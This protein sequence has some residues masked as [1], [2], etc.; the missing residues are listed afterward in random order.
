MQ[1]KI[2][3]TNYETY[4]LL[5][6]DDELSGN[7]RTEVETFLQQHPETQPL[8]D[9]LLR[10]RQ[11]ADPE[12]VFPGKSKL[13]FGAAA[14]T[15]EALLSYLDKEVVPAAVSEAL[16]HP[17]PELAQRL[18]AFEQTIAEPDLSV[19][20]PDKARLYRSSKRI[21]LNMWRVAAA[22]ALVMMAVGAALWMQQQHNRATLAEGKPQR[23][24]DSVPGN[25]RTSLPGEDSAA[26]D[27][28]P[29][30]GRETA[31]AVYKAPDESG[32]ESRR[33]KKEGNT[34]AAVVA[35]VAPAKS[36]PAVSGPPAPVLR[37]TDVVSR[38][39]ADVAINNMENTPPAVLKQD[40]SVHQA[41]V[42]NEEKQPKEK[43]SLFKKL[44]QRIEE[45]VSGALTDGD[46]QVTIAGFAVN[47]K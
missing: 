20:F 19:V 21:S 34:T 4:F 45:R 8:L 9:E 46:G 42:T 11:V 40:P 17:S 24:Q 14:I 12:M 28:V 31:I 1:G 37:S 30:P 18:Q 22:A 47:V 44:T 36:T 29:P 25:N 5:Y 43:K 33:P 38:P 23:P 16:Q 3:P 10:T 2:N 13:L 7:E 39:D 35:T 41:V 26:A 15:D 27:T 6:V 32:N